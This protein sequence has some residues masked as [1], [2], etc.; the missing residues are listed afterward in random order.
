MRAFISRWPNHATLDKLRTQLQDSEQEVCQGLDKIG[1]V[2]E[3]RLELAAENDR[4]Q[5]LLE[6]RQLE[7]AIATAKAALEIDPAY[8]PIRNNLGLSYIHHG[9]L[10]MAQKNS[11]SR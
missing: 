9:E 11:I 2:G 4:V 8:F 7:A 3:N 1:I 10:D 5:L 6:A